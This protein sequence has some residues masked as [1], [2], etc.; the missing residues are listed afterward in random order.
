MRFPVYFHLFGLTLHPHMVMELLAYSAGFQLYLLLRGRWPRREASVPIE[1]AMWL[2]V[3]AVFGAAAGAK[4]LAWL[5]SAQHY[6]AERHHLAV[7]LGGK[8]IV[9]GLLGG[10]AGPRIV[11]KRPG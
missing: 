2:I 4:V 3:G 11:N 6:W 8:T 9:G 7:V 5:E 1:Q 10:W